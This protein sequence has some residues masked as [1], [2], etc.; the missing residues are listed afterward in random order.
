ML[1]NLLGR[2]KVAVYYCRHLR[3]PDKKSASSNDSV[4]GH[5]RAIEL[6]SYTVDADTNVTCVILLLTVHGQVYDRGGL[7][8]QG[9][10]AKGFA[11]FPFR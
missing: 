10:S 3:A 7:T 1:R 4:K 8:A 9:F 6:M 5:R 2:N 11:P